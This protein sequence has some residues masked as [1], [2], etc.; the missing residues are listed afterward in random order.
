VQQYLTLVI[1]DFLFHVLVVVNTVKFA[2][3]FNR[4]DII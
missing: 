3:M 2:D 1:R 4:F